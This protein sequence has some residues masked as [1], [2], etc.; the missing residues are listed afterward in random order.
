MDMDLTTKLQFPASQAEIFLKQIERDVK[1]LQ[2]QEIMDYSLLIGIC[3]KSKTNEEIEQDANG[4]HGQEESYYLG[5]IDVLQEFTINKRM[6]RFA[7]VY[8]LRRD[9]VILLMQTCL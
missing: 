4:I 8:L 7:K 6:E 1:F 2:E 9:A 5:I 3:E